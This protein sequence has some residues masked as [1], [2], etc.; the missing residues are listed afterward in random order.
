MEDRFEQLECDVYNH[1]HQCAHTSEEL[2]KFMQFI[3]VRCLELRSFQSQIMNNVQSCVSDVAILKQSSS[4]FQIESLSM[5]SKLSELEEQAQVFS[6]DCSLS[7]S[8][9]LS[10]NKLMLDLAKSMGALC[11]KLNVSLWN[12]SLF[13]LAESQSADRYL[14]TYVFKLN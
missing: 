13:C 5:R 3:S 12:V 8:S 4:L 1:I 10:H 6:G 9:S 7:V 2:I 14:L 11:A